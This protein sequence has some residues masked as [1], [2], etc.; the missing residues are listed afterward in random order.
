M[1]R[2]ALRSALPRLPASVDRSVVKVIAYKRTATGV[3]S[4]LGCV[5]LVV[6]ATSRTGR[7]S[8]MAFVGAAMFLFGGAWAL[9]DGVRLLRELYSTTAG[10]SFTTREKIPFEPRQ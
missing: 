9:R 5:A 7:P 10:G 8:P 4:L 1:I 2:S 3:M 6:I